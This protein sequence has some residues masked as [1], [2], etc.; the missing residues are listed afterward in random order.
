MHQVKSRMAFQCSKLQCKLRQNKV[1]FFTSGCNKLSKLIW[2]QDP[3]QRIVTSALNASSLQV[4]FSPAEVWCRWSQW[5]ILV[6][7]PRNTKEYEYK[8]VWQTA[9][10]EVM[11]FYLLPDI[12]KFIKTICYWKIRKKSQMQKYFSLWNIYLALENCLI[13]TKN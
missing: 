13:K 5:P 1:V 6:L 8:H 7:S 10:K 11:D 9:C 2:G 3:S 12:S 4:S